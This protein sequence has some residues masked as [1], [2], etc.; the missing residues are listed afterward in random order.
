MNIEEITLSEA[1]RLILKRN[2]RVVEATAVGVP[3]IVNMITKIRGDQH[4]IDDYSLEMK[5]RLAS[6][7]SGKLDTANAFMVGEYEAV[8]KGGLHPVALQFYI[9]EKVLE[10]KENQNAI[11]KRIAY[12]TT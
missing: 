12:Q 4:I 10:E 5:A 9:I 6:K 8:T 11:V 7:I 3:L 1:G 2:G